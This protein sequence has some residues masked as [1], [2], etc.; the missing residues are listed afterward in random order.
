MD[1]TTADLQAELPAGSKLLAVLREVA[2]YRGPGAVVAHL[3][4]YD[5]EPVYTLQDFG[6][7]AIS[8]EPLGT[9]SGHDGSENWGCVAHVTEHGLEELVVHGRER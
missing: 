4:G 7:V 8:L 6:M 5:S 9:F 3:S 2:T 1:I